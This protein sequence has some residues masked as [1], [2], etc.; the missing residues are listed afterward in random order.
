MVK[1]MVQL[2]IILEIKICVWE[3]TLG[4]Q[5]YGHGALNRNETVPYS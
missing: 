4:F 5:F 1:D 2:E 3:R